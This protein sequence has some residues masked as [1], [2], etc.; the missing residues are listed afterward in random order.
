MEI[1]YLRETGWFDKHIVYQ[2]NG[3]KN[4]EEA[5]QELKTLG[6]KFSGEDMW[7]YESYILDVWQNDDG[8]VYMEIFS[9]TVD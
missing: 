5:K 6:Y 1:K 7:F 3:V 9:P 8:L 4:V 2:L